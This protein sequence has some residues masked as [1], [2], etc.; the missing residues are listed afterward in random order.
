MSSVY[1][2]NRYPRL[3]LDANGFPIKV[4]K[5]AF[6]KVPQAL[7]AN[8]SPTADV[9]QD[10]LFINL[11]SVSVSVTTAEELETKVVRIVVIGTAGEGAYVKFGR[12]ETESEVE[13]PAELTANDGPADGIFIPCN[14]PEYF[15]FEGERYVSALR[16]TGTSAM[17]VQIMP[18]A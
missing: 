17:L 15:S 5:P 11:E 10:P 13:N 16:D 6:V 4:M 14:L 1:G 12:N 7:D 8:A 18:M 3:P 9:Y 2:K